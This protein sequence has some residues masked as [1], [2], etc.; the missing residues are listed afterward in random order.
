MGSL[1]VKGSKLWIRYKDESG[2]WVGAPTQCRPHEKAR[3]RRHLAKIESGITALADARKAADLPPGAPLTVAAYTAK[4]LADRKRL[5]LK[6]LADDTSRMRLHVLPRIG[7]MLMHEVR[8]RHLRELVLQ[9]REAGKL[10]PRTLC[11]VYHLTATMFRTAV[12]EEIIDATP[13]VLQRG[14]LPKKVD[15][16]PSWRATAIYTREEIE[17]LIADDRIP[18]DR[19]VL[20]ALKSLA[21]LRHGEAAGLTWRQYDATMEP[22]GSLSLE[23]TKT[24]VP[25]RV[26]VHPTLAVILSEWKNAG[27]ERTYGREPVSEDLIVPTRNMT[28]RTAQETPKQLHDDLTLLNLRRRRGHDLRRTFITLAQVDGA[29]RDLLETISHGPRGDI[30]SIYTTFPWP[31]LCAEVV[32]LG[33]ELRKT[34][35]NTEKLS[36]FATGFATAHV[37]GRNR[38][39]NSVTPS[40]IEPEIA[41]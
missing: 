33:I 16:D 26:P 13:C 15:K 31:A 10:A 35:E 5:G 7:T 24:Q 34:P 27:W 11:H 29:R 28:I 2:K 40:G 37:R 12:A 36:E 4:W 9:L 14:V 39:R 6:S 17:R 25:R 8:P 38:W 30:V 21:G 41:P 1:Y 19:R 20:Y 23:H 32:K 3:A 22:L 18:E